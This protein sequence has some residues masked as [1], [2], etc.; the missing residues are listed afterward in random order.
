[1][2]E[3]TWRDYEEFIKDA[4]YLNGTV[5][6][7]TKKFAKC[8][9]E[10]VVNCDGCS[11]KA[12]IEIHSTNLTRLKGY[13]NKEL[14]LRRRF[15]VGRSIPLSCYK[16]YDENLWHSEYKVV[17]VDHAHHFS[18]ENI[19]QITNGSKVHLTF[20]IKCNKLNYYIWVI[21][22]TLDEN[23]PIIEFAFWLFLWKASLSLFN[24]LIKLL[25]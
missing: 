17:I 4:D 2:E 22:K 23:I 10:L 9:G 6:D 8:Y 24:P 13:E 14:S 19:I 12:F 16:G 15:K 7:L 1:M 11:D 20:E 3:V 18:E 21:N 25:P 5:V